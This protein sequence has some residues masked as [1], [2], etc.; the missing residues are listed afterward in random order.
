MNALLLVTFFSLML[1]LPIAAELGLNAAVAV[2]VEPTVSE[3]L[4]A[5]RS[6]FRSTRFP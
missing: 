1:L 5:Q 4:I 3:A 6:S 2:A